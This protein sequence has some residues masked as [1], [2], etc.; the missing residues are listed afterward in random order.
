VDVE[1][2]KWDFQHEVSLL[3]ECQIGV[4]PVLPSDWGPWKFFFKLIQFMSLGLPVVATPIGSN[5]EIIKD[6][7]NGFLAKDANEWHD[8][9]RLLLDDANLRRRMGAEARQTVEAEFS[10]E[11]Q[12]DL[13]ESVFK[14]A[15]SLR[16]AEHSAR[17]VT[18]L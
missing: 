16:H 2:I 14:N 8:R 11:K 6:G 9:L 12:I 18:Q 4:V 17:V 7:V 3:Q 15:V 10:L 5:L 13:I 1:F